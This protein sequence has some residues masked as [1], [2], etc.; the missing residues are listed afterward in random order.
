MVMWELTL[1]VAIFV[2][3]RFQFIQHLGLIVGC[4]RAE[5]LFDSGFVQGH[6]MAERFMAQQRAFLVQPAQD[7][8]VEITRPNQSDLD[9]LALACI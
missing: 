5:M 2:A 8:D 3:Q 1:I 7:F 4:Q 6:G 9:I